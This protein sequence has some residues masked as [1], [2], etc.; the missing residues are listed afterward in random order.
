[1]YRIKPRVH[2][3]PIRLGHYSVLNLNVRECSGLLRWR[4]KAVGG[5]QNHKTLATTR[6]HCA[7]ATV[8]GT[9]RSVS[10]QYFHDSS[11][12]VANARGLNQPLP[13]RRAVGRHRQRNADRK[14]AY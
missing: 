7:P 1:M 6:D 13:I 5:G 3:N 10:A 8:R 12:N 11:G 4:N 2:E 9:R 14:G